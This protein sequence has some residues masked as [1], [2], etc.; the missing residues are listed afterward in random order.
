[1]KWIFKAASLAA[2]FFLSACSISET[3]VPVDQI[4][5]APSE[6]EQSGS[7]NCNVDGSAVR[8]EL[9]IQT[10]ESSLSLTE[11]VG[12]CAGVSHDKNT[13]SGLNRFTYCFDVSGTCNEAG[14][15]S[16]VIVAKT[17]LDGFSTKN[18]VGTCKRGRF[19]VQIQKVLT[20]CADHANNR[21]D[22]NHKFCAQ[23]R[24]QL[25]LVGKKADGTEV[26]NEARAKKEIPFTVNNRPE[27]SP[28]PGSTFTA[29][30]L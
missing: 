1:M 6:C 14:L 2:L 23:H 16:A 26:R 20:G 8:L 17:S 10:P 11:S 24:L 4:S 19:H 29:N 7:E 3:G 18:V 5:S 15:E 28:P 22:I 9:M 30:C 13:A 21:Y 27:C 25:E 12:S